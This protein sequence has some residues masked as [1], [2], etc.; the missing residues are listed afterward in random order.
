MSAGRRSGRWA[1]LARVLPNAAAS[2]PAVGVDEGAGG[3]A[4]VLPVRLDLAEV[5][6]LARAARSGRA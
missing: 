1:V 4:I 5:E 3:S 2:L 6:R